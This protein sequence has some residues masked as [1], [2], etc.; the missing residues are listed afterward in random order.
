MDWDFDEFDDEPCDEPPA[1]RR[2]ELPDPDR[3]WVHADGHLHE[4]PPLPVARVYCMEVG[5]LPI[6]GGVGWWPPIEAPACGAVLDVPP[7]KTAD[8]Q[9]RRFMCDRPDGHTDGDDPGPHRTV[10]WN[11]SPNGG[12]H[13]VPWPAT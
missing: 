1:L 10:T 4:E 2:I 9:R 5:A 3:T 12:G 8:G 6:F 11:L 7:E 13:S